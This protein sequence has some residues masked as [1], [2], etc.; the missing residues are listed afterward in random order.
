MIKIGVT[1]TIGSGKSTIS[2]KFRDMGIP[3]FDADVAGKQVVRADPIL[4]VLVQ[5]SNA[6]GKSIL[7]FPQRMNE[8]T[9]EA[10]PKVMEKWR[11]FVKD[12]KWDKIVVCDIPLLFESK[13]ENEF[14]YI[15]V[16]S[17]PKFILKQRVMKRG[18]SESYF[19]KIVR[20]QIPTKTKE[21]KADF[22]LYTGLGQGLTNRQF[23]KLV[24]QFH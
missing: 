10:T 17:C 20:R 7:D 2:K 18:K 3:V 5:Y 11:Q 23:A 22:V 6:G 1:G 9:R 24:S 16:I 13:A 4:Y 12:H 15:V 19:E 8:L 14:D 21:R